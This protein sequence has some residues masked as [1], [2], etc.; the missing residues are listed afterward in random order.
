MAAGSPMNVSVDDSAPSFGDI[1][2]NEDEYGAGASV[3]ARRRVLGDPR[4]LYGRGGGVFGLAKLSDRLMDVW[5]EN[6]L[7]NAN[8]SVAKWH[9]SRQKFGFK[10][11]VTQLFGYLTG[12]P[13]RYTGRSMEYSHKHLGISIA[14]WNS[15][16][17][18]AS[19]VF[20]EFNLEQS[21]HQEL[22]AVIQGFQS[23]CTVQPGEAVP[24][25]PGLS[26]QRP[27]GEHSYAQLGG[28]YP[29][30]H[31]VNDLVDAVLQGPLALR[32]RW[33]ANGPRSP[34]ALKYL[35]TELLANA[36]GGPEV[37]TA[38]DFEDAKLGIDVEQWDNFLLLVN[39]KASHW[40]T[41]EHRE[42]VINAIRTKKVQICVGLVDQSDVSD[43]RR[44]LADAGFGT[45]ENAAALDRCGGDATAAL[46]LLRSG[47]RPE[48]EMRWEDS[49]SSLAPINTHSSAFNSAGSGGYSSG[50][51]ASSGS[52]GSAGYSSAAQA[53]GG[54]PFFSGTGGNQSLAGQPNSAAHTTIQV[55]SEC[56]KSK[57]EITQMIAVSEAEVDAALKQDRY[58]IAA[59]IM[60]KKKVKLQDIAK[61]LKMSEARVHG[62]ICGEVSGQALGG[63]LL[64]NAL[65]RRFDELCDEDSEMCCPVTLMLFT[66]PVI[67]SD[68]FMYEAEAAKQL[69]LNRQRSPITREELKNTCIA[70][71]QKKSEVI[72]FRE[73][74]AQSLL[75]F[76]KDALP[77]EP[78]MTSM[79]L[80]RVMEYLEVLKASSHPAIAREAAA[81]WEQTGRPLPNALRPHLGMS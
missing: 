73:R 22:L 76:A 8:R 18:D 35:F 14:E 3:A 50:V 10:F 2:E 11:L 65:Q 54:C 6:H 5:M 27:D 9:E 61:I 31:Y 58:V 52:A 30:A 60:S 71:K 49:D 15:F 59:R 25:D 56:G 57:A 33:D 62:A 13:Q 26:R 53:S 68:G 34:A 47:W 42:L 1:A 51:Q 24:D 16:V 70:A 39:Q 72:A 81:I 36:T 38:K 45:I 69:I 67:A 66:D 78:R 37:V 23:Q 29:I 55:L 63:R 20:R 80:D 44:Q 32:V 41:P 43:A 74:R 75:Q 64:G 46:E 21:V 7:L 19:R 79:A 17:A 48:S 77:T 40:A 28:I 4:T 12:G